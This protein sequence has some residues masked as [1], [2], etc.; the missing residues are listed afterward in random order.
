MIQTFLCAV[1]FHT[2]NKWHKISWST[3][4]QER[5]CKNCGITQMRSW[6]V[7]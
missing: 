1:G 2:W 6:Y 3:V 4:L 5:S 7:R